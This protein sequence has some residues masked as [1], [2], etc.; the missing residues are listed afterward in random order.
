MHVEKI[1]FDNAIGTIKNIEGK[2][3]DSLNTCL[4]IEEMGIWHLLYPRE[5]NGKIKLPPACY[6]LS[7]DEK[8]TYA[9]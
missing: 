4:D 6:T 1:I 8:M 2:T 7:N 9:N 5:V 3:K